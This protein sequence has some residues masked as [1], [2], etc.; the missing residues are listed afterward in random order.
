MGSRS[1]SPAIDGVLEAGFFRIGGSGESSRGG[2][3]RLGNG[4]SYRDE[5]DSGREKCLR[6]GV[7][8][9]LRGGGLTLR[10]R[11][12][13]DLLVGRLGGDCGRRL[14]GIYESTSGAR[15]LESGR[16]GRGGELLLGGG[17]NSRRL[18]GPGSLESYLSLLLDRLSRLLSPNPR[19][20]QSEGDGLR[21]RLRFENRAGDESREVKADSIGYRL[22]D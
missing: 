22:R 7:S 6:G 14:S 3:R 9:L 19:S 17:E 12:E 20:L 5:G 10:G 15:S 18:G 16:A 11:G 13:G 21:V 8:D 4:D 2:P 1:K